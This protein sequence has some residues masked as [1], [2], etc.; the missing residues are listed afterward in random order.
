[1]NI[2]LDR[3]NKIFAGA[4]K[5]GRSFLL[6][7]EV[8]A[9][10][11]AVGLGAPRFFFL[12]K[13]KKA[14]PR[15]LA[16]LGTDSVVLKVV[17]PLI[18]HKS[19]AGGVRFVKADAAAVNQAVGEMLASVPVTF[20]TW[21]RKFEKP[22]E[23]GGPARKD[24]ETS[25]RG[26]L[27]C[28]KIAYDNVGFGSEILA[29][30]KDSREF[31]PV[32]TVGAGGLDVEYMNEK[33]RDGKAVSL[34]SVHLFDED[35]VRT[36]LEPLA[37]FGKVAKAF[38]GRKPLITPESLAGSILR[39]VALTRSLS[40]Y[41]G[42]SPYVIEEFEVNPLVIR[43]GKLV[44]LDGLCRF[45][46]AHRELTA[47]PYGQIRSLLR[48]DTIGII[49]VSE[50]M[51][52]GHIILNNILKNGFPKERVF[53]VKPGAAEIEGCRCVPAVRDLPGTVDMFVLTLG[54]EQSYDVMKEII[55]NGKAR[56]VIIIAGGLGE[57]QGTQGLE[58]MIKDLIAR[59]REE[60][61]TTP[62]V[63][64]GNCL[65][66]AS[67]PGK[68]DTTFITDHKLPRPRGPRSDMAV[69]SQSGA[70]MIS[71]MSKMPH[72]EPRYAVSLGNQ[73]DLTASDYLN[74]LKD[75]PEVRTFAVYMEG[76]R[77]GD[78]Y[79]FARAVEEITARGRTVVV[80]KSGRSPEGRG[81]A[82]SHTASVAG[83]YN[84]CRSILK[85]AGAIVCEDIEEYES[86]VR[87]VH[88]LEGRKVRGN[89][90]G[91]VSN[92]GFECVIMA[93]SL[94]D[95]EAEL[96]LA[97]F[98]PATRSRIVETLKPLG[99]DKLQDVHNPLDVTPVGDDAVFCACAEAVLEDPN[100]DC[101]VI[102]PVPMTP[103]M[104]ML[105]PSDAY[106]ESILSPESF[107]Q[108]IVATFRK[109]DK[110]FVVNVDAG[111]VYDP[112]CELLDEAGIPVFRRSDEALRFLRK[113]V[114]ARLPRS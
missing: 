84:I 19:D 112:L 82:S 49:G 67:K 12:E 7:H 25:I 8:Y 58:G 3:V 11:K 70:F 110:P 10:L 97:E 38:R 6:E 40:A 102:S 17:S 35:R 74:Y 32:M 43:R 89:R 76:F 65:G 48:P 80:Y 15:D 66:I 52:I 21:A 99:I 88:G 51:N 47:R 90:V 29:G 93:D 41:A 94:K 85:Q 59:G 36:L 53:V 28:E 100:V 16:G 75:E 68:Y 20:R 60:G 50:K 107:A 54:A 72:I 103:A 64:G 31:G 63:N 77:S 87:G 30:V 26:I 62:V 81:A 104:Q 5:D 13:G 92:A 109:T 79:A 83:D 96:V 101:A 1:M 56:S 24:V 105:A 27:V 61:R 95:D 114:A 34:F 73:I 9:M 111:K 86:F 4:E 69:I 33:I 37:F 42:D 108:R 44:P 91:L 23:K 39:F 78:G 14:R 98:A 22:G 45:S 2:N 106:K 57:K 71:R 113:Y 18:Q 55:E 46:R